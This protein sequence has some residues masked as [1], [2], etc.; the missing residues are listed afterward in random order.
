M[1]NLTQALYRFIRTS[2][3]CR[4]MPPGGSQRP[5]GAVA[6]S[7]AIAAL[8]AE[9]LRAWWDG[10]NE[11]LRF[12]PAPIELTLEVAVTAAGEGSL[13]V[14]WW[15]LELGGKASRE[16]V[17]TQTIK[18]TLD[19]KIFDPSGQPLRVLIDTVDHQGHAGS[20]EPVTLDAAG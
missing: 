5:A 16:K 7:D 12:E 19:P 1:L 9:L 17:S 2:R 8:R 13:G 6:L 3:R 14:N 15:V 11:I 18:I 10:R 20:D 4:A